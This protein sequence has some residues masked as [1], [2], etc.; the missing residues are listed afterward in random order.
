MILISSVP[1]LIMTSVLTKSVVD[2]LAM[3]PARIIAVV[4]TGAVYTVV[5]VVPIAFDVFL[6]N[7]F[8]IFAVLS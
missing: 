1:S 7:V 3:V 2:V 4:A 5:N 8:A 6:K